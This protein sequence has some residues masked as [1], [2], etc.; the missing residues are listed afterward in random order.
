MPRHA[1]GSSIPAFSPAVYAVT[2]PTW[3]AARRQPQFLRPD[4]QFNQALWSAENYPRLVDRYFGQTKQV[5]FYLVSG[6]S[7]KLGIAFET[8]L[9]FK[10]L[11]EKQPE[12]VELRIVD[13][14]HDWDVWDKTLDDAL[15]YLFLFTQRPHSGSH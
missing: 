12:Q 11:F 2:P 4:G 9:L 6:D 14:G 3:S 15:K 5:A 13:G 8:A 7:D 10:T 1:S